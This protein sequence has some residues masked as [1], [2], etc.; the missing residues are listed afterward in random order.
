M[1]KLL[2]IF[3]AL[4]LLTGCGT[5]ASSGA[6]T[7]A[8]EEGAADFRVGFAMADITPDAPVPLG[9]Y[10]R[11]DLRIS[12]G[13]VSRL[14]AS[15]LAVTDE[16]GETVLLFSMDQH[17]AHHTDEIR[18]A[19]NKATGVLVE[20]IV[21]SMTHTHSA[22]DLANK[23][24]LSIQSYLVLLERQAAAAAEEALADRKPATISGGSIATEGLNFIRH[25]KM[26]DGTYAGDNFG[27]TSSGYAGHH[28]DADPILQLL[29][30][31]REGG[32]DIYVTNFQTHP[33][34]TGGF[35]KYEISAD[36]VGEYR[37][38]MEQATNAHVMYFSGA[39]GNINSTS[40]IKDEQAAKDHKD[41]G[42]RLADY[43]QKVQLQPLKAGAVKVTTQVFQGEVNH[44][45]DAY[46][47][48]CKDLYEQWN[49]GKIDVEELKRRGAEAG[50]KLNSGQNARSISQRVTMGE[51]FDFDI[52]TVSI[53]E[54]AMVVAPFE[55]FDT[56]G[57]YI[58]EG[59]PF[60]MTFIATLANGTVGYL[61]TRETFEYGSYET[62]SCRF[63]PG[64]A[65]EVA[66]AFL[67]MLKAQYE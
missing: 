30:F 55:M 9:G 65:E 12:Q 57:S 1:K 19:V 10:S 7:V 48:L 64:I 25:Y 31:A 16:A 53:G 5:P 27:D 61:P 67:A 63:S 37:S 29:K 6:E 59:S 18:K 22:P 3:L 46:A 60:A 28:H 40:R 66:D 58:R 14:Y 15:C 52:A 42:N 13:F 56:I 32:K 50:I 36:V 23:K 17:N 33:H 20:H 39:G 24:Q 8:G 41:W 49:A 54:V 51:T 26:N 38:A 47:A 45:L 2:T 62:D 21:V 4:L 43:A 34:Q 35:E 44:S 11:S